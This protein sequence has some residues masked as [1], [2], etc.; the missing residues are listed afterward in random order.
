MKTRSR[1]IEQDGVPTALPEATAAAHLA[2]RPGSLK[3]LYDDK[4]FPDVF[5]AI[6]KLSLETSLPLPG[7]VLFGSN[8]DNAA[9]KLSIS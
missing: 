1:E 6:L 2:T 4:V 5:G 7:R 3:I 9:Q 8:S